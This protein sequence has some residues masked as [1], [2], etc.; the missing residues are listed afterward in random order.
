VPDEFG[1]NVKELLER[2]KWLWFAPVLATAALL[3]GLGWL[4]SSRGGGGRGGSP[5]VAG[6]TTSPAN[7]DDDGD[8]E[9]PTTITPPATAVPAVEKVPLK[10]TLHTG[11]QGDAVKRLQNRLVE[12]HFDPGKID[13][14]YGTSTQMAVWAYESLLLGRR[15]NDLTGKVTPDVWDGMQDAISVSPR[16]SNTTSTHLEIYLPEQ[17][18]VLFKDGQP[19]LVTHISTGSGQDWCED[20][21]CG[22]A[23]TPGG[24]F[25]F[26]RRESGWWEG[27]LGR[28][29]NP[30]YFN[31]GI[32]V[33]GMTNVPVYPASHG[34]VRIPMHIAQYFPSMVKNGDLVYVFDGV[35][36]PEVYGKQKP[37]FDTKDPN[38][39]TTT[40]STEELPD[41]TAPPASTTTVAP[42]P[43][44]TAVATTVAPTTVAATTTTT[45]PTG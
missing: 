2:M 17:V 26:N 5:D 9:T 34:C 42:A 27:P 37:P 12:M 22:T 4:G 21:R 30:V 14:I 3:V 24:V 43:T 15:G 8:L 32:A 31:Y 28:M 44:T 39:T 33:H 25:R 23:I 16:R 10:T 1:P 6:G 13:G 38:A 18:A 41:I 20:G 45:A 11:S 29:F 36:E 7:P 40:S 19:Q 35:K